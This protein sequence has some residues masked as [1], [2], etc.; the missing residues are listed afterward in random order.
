MI[1]CEGRA[2]ARGD[3][4]GWVCRSCE[5]GREREVVGAVLERALARLS[6]SSEDLRAAWRRQQRERRKGLWSPT[7][8]R[9]LRRT[10]SPSSPPKSRESDFKERA[11]I[12]LRR[13]AAGLGAS[14]VGD[15][16]VGRLAEFFPPSAQALRRAYEACVEVLPEGDAE[17]W[18]VVELAQ[19][20]YAYWRPKTVRVVLLAESHVHTAANEAAR[21]FG[22]LEGYDGPRAF[23]ALVYCLGYGENEALDAP[24]ERNKGTPQFWQ[25]LAAARGDTDAGLLK[26]DTKVRDRRLASKLELLRALKREGIWLVDASVVGFYIPQAPEYRRSPV[27]GDVHR[28]SKSRPP[29]G[30][31]RPALVVS[32]ELYVKHVVREAA[33]AGHLRAVVPIGMEVWQALGRDRL[34]LAATAAATVAEPLPAPNAWLKGGYG[35]HLAHLTEFRG[36][37][38]TAPEV[39]KI[40][41]FA[42]IA[43]IDHGKSTLADR[44]LE[45]TKTVAMRDMQAQLLDSMDLER[46]RGIT[47]KLNSARMTYQARDGERYIL[48]MFD[49]PGHVD[50]SYEVSRSLAA[51]EGALLIVDAAQGVQAQTLANVYLALENDLE[52]IPVLNKI[53]LPAAEPDRVAEEIET[54]IGLDCSD[55]VPCSAKSGLGV[56]EVLE[57]I[58]ARVP[59][60]RN[61]PEASSSGPT[62]ALI[63]DSVFDAF[64]G[65]IVYFRVIDG[66]GIKKGDRVKFLASGKAYDA[67]EVGVMTPARIPVTER[68]LGPGEVGYLCAAIKQVDDARVGDTIT[69]L[70][71]GL[72]NS[73][74]DGVEAL[75]GYAEATPMVYAGVFPVDADQY[76]PLRDALG[77]L[78]LNDAALRYETENS[79]AMG[80]GFRCGFL[81]LLHMEIVQERL[82]REYDLDL[83]ITAPA[84]VYKVVPAGPEAAELVDKILNDE[85]DERIVSVDNPSRMP[86]KERNQRVLEPYV[87]LEIIA[88]TDFTGALIELAQER[89]GELVDVKYL[90]QTRTTIVYDIP[91][92]EVITD[93]FDQVKSRTRGFASM[94]YAISGYRESPLVRLDVK[95]NGE[96]APPL[97]TVVHEADAQAA[98][99]VLVRKL[100]D[101]IPRQL[102][103]IPIQACVGVQPVASVQISALRKDVLAKC[104]GGDISR[105]KKLL[106]KQAKG[107]KRMKQMGKV[108]VP[109]EAFMSVLNLRDADGDY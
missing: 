34:E 68:A 70:R 67:T 28:L 45:M 71:R 78:K 102:F 43:H 5:R 2:C 84:V 95:I 35:P 17:E 51:C 90:T 58:V 12:A 37:L 108:S 75:P 92:A 74:E 86:D 103:K 19:A 98:G 85:E 65:V 22:P 97:S 23:V 42:I 8:R 89:R 66:P 1:A 72:S 29:K 94:E 88:P 105:K 77:K 21:S 25:L 53:D 109:Q 101:F 20:Y 81:G 52:I 26:R 33:D 107:K 93:F 62:R 32:W 16:Y 87:K 69:V 83:V 36:A 54:T 82:E 30:A 55:A 3:E 61:Q 14:V 18:G 49:S 99:K 39:S 104:Y 40:R 41:N 9:S 44:M 50:F 76:G 64:R 47:I 46:E 106:Q 57:A 79:P 56:D 38:E 7:G 10:K 63:F 60:P 24:L 11:G 48:N 4:E 31:K 6:E 13:G 91:L 59:P 27:S 73:D 100:K 15:E 96:I 80:F